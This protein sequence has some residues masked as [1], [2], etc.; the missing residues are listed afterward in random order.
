MLAEA[1]LP[2]DPQALRA[3]L[4]DRDRQVTA[5]ER[6]KQEAEAELARLGAII[7]AL[8]RHRFGARS[9]QLHP[10]QL[11]LAL[12]EIDAA[13]GRVQAGLDAV[14]AEPK[15]ARPRQRNRGSLPVIFPRCGGHL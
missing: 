10:D 4:V 12:E 7:A 15:E 2:S 5:L 11:L 14:A 8:Q 3:M 6:A 9:E 13:V 1:D